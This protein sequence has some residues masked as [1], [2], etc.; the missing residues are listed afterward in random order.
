MT[1]YCQKLEVF[2]CL[3]ICFN[4]Q[5]FEENPSEDSHRIIYYIFIHWYT[6][7]LHSDVPGSVIEKKKKVKLYNEHISIKSTH[8]YIY[9]FC[10]FVKENIYQTT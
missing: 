7:I 6:C 4:C 8:S 10:F 1:F 5:K 9:W 2:I 3:V